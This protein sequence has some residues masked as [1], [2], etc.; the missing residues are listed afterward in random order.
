M[1][2]AAHQIYHP[3]TTFFYWVRSQ[4]GSPSKKAAIQEG[5]LRIKEIFQ[6]QGLSYP[7]QDVLLVGIKSAKKLL[8]FIDQKPRSQ[9]SENPL[10]AGHSSVDEERSWT[11]LKKY[12]VLASSGALGP[13]LREGDRQVPEGVYRVTYKNEQSRFHLALRL[14]YPNEYDQSQGV[15]DE[16][17]HLGGDIMIHGSDVSVGCLAI[18]NSGIEEIYALAADTNID[19]WRVI[20]MPTWPS[21][22]PQLKSESEIY[23]KWYPDLLDKIHDEIV[24]I[25]LSL[26]LL[27]GD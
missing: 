23:P 27:K 5:R 12:P 2:K 7:P 15:L 3:S 19:R 13:K 4:L 26:D 24:T 10:I 8:V 1:L 6:K 21:N 25:N 16:R 14:N 9:P 18:G 22:F 17:D 20:L 11:V